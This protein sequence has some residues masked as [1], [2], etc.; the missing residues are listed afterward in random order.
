MLELL[1]YTNLCKQS[2]PILAGSDQLANL[3]MQHV[4]QCPAG[5]QEYQLP[6]NDCSQRHHSPSL[7]HLDLIPSNLNALLLI[8]CLEHRLERTTSK[9]SIKLWVVQDE[10][11]AMAPWPVPSILSDS[12]MWMHNLYACNQATQP[13]M[14]PRKQPPAATCEP[15]AACPSITAARWCSDQQQ[16]ATCV[17][18]HSGLQDHAPRLVVPPRPRL[19]GLG[20]CSPELPRSLPWL[21]LVLC[22]GT[23]VELP[24]V[25]TCNHYDI[26]LLQ[27]L[28]GQGVARWWQVCGIQ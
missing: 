4:V 14:S 16:S 8:K 9:D 28:K 1:Q 27:L 21:V 20:R 15:P 10:C 2:V 22:T 17:P 3:Y 13:H 18:F 12:T 19:E 26:T 5:N 6:C 25:C 11:R 23:T 24:N 7:A